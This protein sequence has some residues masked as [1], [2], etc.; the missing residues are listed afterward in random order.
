MSKIHNLQIVYEGKEEPTPIA[1]IDANLTVQKLLNAVSKKLQLPDSALKSLF[2]KN[3][4]NPLDPTRTLA[5]ASVS[6]GETLILKVINLQQGTTVSSDGQLSGPKGILRKR[7]ADVA[8]CIDCTE[9]MRPCIE[10]V[11]K[12]VQELVKG[13]QEER[14]IKLDWR[15]RLIEYRDLNEGKKLSNI[16]S[17]LAVKNLENKFRSYEPPG[18]DPNLKVLWMQYLKPC[19]LP[20]VTNVINLL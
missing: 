9:S 16:P 6:N 13:F 15:V 12:H 7:L 5:D 18:V 19:I 2:R 10:G 17:L 14:S 8:I 3:T 20:G 1:K 11:K 4:Q